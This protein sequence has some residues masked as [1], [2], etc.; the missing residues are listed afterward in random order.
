MSHHESRSVVSWMM[1]NVVDQ[2]FFSKKLKLPSRPAQH[3]V[4]QWSFFMLH[5][6]DLQVLQ[7]ANILRQMVGRYSGWDARFARVWPLLFHCDECV[8]SFYLYYLQMTWWLSHRRTYPQ[9][10]ESYVMSKHPL[11]LVNT[12]WLRPLSYSCSYVIGPSWA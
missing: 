4:Q 3:A 7:R 8:F 10:A 5:D 2:Y 12:T 6:E 1:L 11:G 9:N